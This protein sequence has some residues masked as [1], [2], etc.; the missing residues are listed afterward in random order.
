MRRARAL[1]FDTSPMRPSEA[2]DI[3]R[4]NADFVKPAHRRK[5]QSATHLFH[6]QGAW[7]SL[8]QFCQRGQAARKIGR[9]F[10]LQTLLQWIEVHDHCARLERFHEL[11]N[12]HDGTLDN[13]R[14][15]QISQQMDIGNLLT[16]ARPL[17][18]GITIG[19]FATLRSHAHQPAATI[20]SSCQARI[21]LEC[22]RVPP[23]HRANEEGS[24]H[25][26]AQYVLAYLH[27]RKI[28]IRKSFVTEVDFIEA[29]AIARLRTRIEGPTNVVP[30]PLFKLFG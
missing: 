21:H 4:V 7:Q 27:V 9:A 15:S 14:D 25:F 13:L 22:V 30:L 1:A 18:A 29:C 8:A 28:K 11:Q 16:E 24:A 12:M 19:E 10:G 20:R 23:G 3:D 2:A 6:N 17:S 5:R 26:Q